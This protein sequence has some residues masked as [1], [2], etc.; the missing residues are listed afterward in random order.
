MC[1]RS[2]LKLMVKTFSCCNTFNN[3][4]SFLWNSDAKV[5]R[6]CPMQTA[7]QKISRSETSKR[8][9]FNKIE[10]W[11]SK[12]LSGKYKISWGRFLHSASLRSK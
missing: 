4:K 6:H 5:F 8:L 10:F 12:L 9:I 2:I 11:P 7:I 1:L 3:P